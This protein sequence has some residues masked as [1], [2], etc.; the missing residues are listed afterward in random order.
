MKPT[1][2]PICRNN[3]T[4][5][6]GMIPAKDLLV[7]RCNRCDKTFLTGKEGQCKTSW[8]A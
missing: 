5:Y 4:E 8:S 3:Q 6:I 2:C 7:W 1:P